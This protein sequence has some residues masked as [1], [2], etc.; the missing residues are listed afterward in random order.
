MLGLGQQS[1][2][3][4]GIAIS[5]HDRFSDKANKINNQLKM[6]QQTARNSAVSA[7]R[8]YRSYQAGILASTGAATYGMVR[9]AEQGAEINHK[10]TQI[11]VLGE[12]KIKKSSNNIRKSIGDISMEFAKKPMDIGEAL[13]ENIR[14]G[15]T[16][17]LDLITR[18]QAAAASITG[19]Q[20]G[21]ENGVAG[22]LLGIMNAYN[23]TPKDFANI[24]NAVTAI[25]N[26]TKAS[27]GSIG[28]SMEYAAFSS[29]Q[30][31]IPLEQTIAL[32]GKLS[33]ASIEGSSAGTKLNN[34][35]VQLAKQTGATAS[36]KATKYWGILGINPKDIK[37]MLDQGKLFDIISLIDD[38]SSRLSKSDKFEALQTLLNIRGSQ[39]A[40]GA[41]GN[42]DPEKRLGHWDSKS[43]TG[44]GLLGEA[45]KG[46]LTDI[47]INKARKTTNDF[48][49]DIDRLKAKWELYKTDFSK[50]FEPLGRLF[51]RIGN[52]ALSVFSAI[53][54]SKVGGVLVSL[55]AVVVPVI[56]LFAAARFA[57]ASFV[58]ALN[59]ASK[60]TAMG[61]GSNIMQGA[62]GGLFGNLGKGSIGSVAINK[63]GRHYVKP[64]HQVLHNGKIYGREKGIANLPHDFAGSAGGT[65]IGNLIGRIF[66]KT[67][68]STATTAVASATTAATSKG[69]LS[70]V[71][72][73][74]ARFIPIAGWLFLAYE[75]LTGISDILTD[76]GKTEQERI[77]EGYL[78][79]LLDQQM[80]GNKN[81]LQP[82]NRNLNQ[83]II[84]N[85]NGVNTGQVTSE[86]ALDRDNLDLLHNFTNN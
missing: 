51:I 71:T 26:A 43:K 24:T 25:A 3:G 12:G 79:K 22:K 56:G 64:G 14:A 8:D 18:Y 86:M 41:F 32:I 15:I 59:T 61:G 75:A 66:G 13:L 82:G 85:V 58:I 76:D 65:V 73:M 7:V 21:G 38:A 28:E 49:S 27:V 37:G 74:G 48:Y 69:I 80:N 20:L 29:A 23:K 33:Q 60:L 2:L 78:L 62:L 5:L 72:R 19:E 77:S 83:N 68:S 47:T 11:M 55:G 52:A 40:M 53:T 9:M 6:M 10:I 34:M 63:A 84:L 16:T 45:M 1:Q 44:S 57:L 67:A 70:A 54:Q 50:A 39:A 36:K 81:P 35:F 4:I 17:D 31:G 46:Q 42:A 30:L